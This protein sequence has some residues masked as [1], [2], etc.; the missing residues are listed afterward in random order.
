MYSGHKSTLIRQKEIIE[1]ARKVVIKYGS[2]NVTIKEIARDVGI[3][4]GAIYRHFKSKRE[5]LDGLADHVIKELVND[6]PDSEISAVNDKT[7]VEQILKRHISRIEKGKG[8]SFQVIAEIISFGDMRLNGKIY[9]GLEA[10]IARLKKLVT[11]FSK[12]YGDIEAEAASY[13][14][15]GLIQGLV[16]IWTLSNYRFD[17]KEKYSKAWEVLSHIL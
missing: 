8:A 15:F 3:T 7:E 12:G 2:E 13:I 11:P 10:Y 5:V 4:E 17:L 1:A 9:A 6:I 14:L 16:N